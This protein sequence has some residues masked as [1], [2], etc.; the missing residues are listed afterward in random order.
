MLSWDFRIRLFPMA[1]DMDNLSKATCH[2][3]EA[4]RIVWQQKGRIV[5]LR[6]AG[7]DTLDAERTLRV[8][9]ANLQAFQEHKRALEFNQQGA[10]SG[11]HLRG[12]PTSL[13]RLIAAE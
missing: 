12:W 10:F 7:L 1:A 4:Q 3:E 9:E 5:R 8:L 2:V 6:T 13:P 11:V